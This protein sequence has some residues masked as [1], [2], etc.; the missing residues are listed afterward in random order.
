[1]QA[2]RITYTIREGS[3]EEKEEEAWTSFWKAWNFRPLP[4]TSG[5]RNLRSSRSFRPC[6]TEAVRECANSL[7]S[8][9]PA[10]T[11]TRNLRRPDLPALPARRHWGRSPC[12]L[13]P[14]TYPFMDLDYIY[15]ST[16]SF[17]GLAL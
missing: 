17:L 9:D 2:P 13:S 14:L 3:V 7:D 16:S 11:F 6:C 8:P 15:S 1:M 10:Q 12:T 4:G 5:H